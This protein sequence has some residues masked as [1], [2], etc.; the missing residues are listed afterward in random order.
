MFTSIGPTLIFT[1]LSVT[2]SVRLKSD[3]SAIPPSRLF[4]V[5]RAVST[6]LS[7][8]AFTQAFLILSAID[9]AN[10]VIPAAAA[11]IVPSSIVAPPLTSF[12]NSG[13]SY[14]ESL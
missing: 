6:I 1:P 3:E 9:A 13:R 12:V 14:I 10:P 8:P 5:S 4:S 7:T 11:P 2:A